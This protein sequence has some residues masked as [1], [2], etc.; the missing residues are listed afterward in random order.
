MSSSNFETPLDVFTAA[1]FSFQDPRKVLVTLGV[2]FFLVTYII[3]PQSLFNFFAP[4]ICAGA[5]FAGS[6]WL[7]SR[8]NA[9]H[10][11]RGDLQKERK[12]LLEDM[13]LDRS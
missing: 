10:I 13:G 3:P 1:G 8:W 4:M 2:A 7:H 9:K 12:T 5:L 6:T 11:M